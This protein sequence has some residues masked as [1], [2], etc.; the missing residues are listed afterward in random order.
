MYPASG[1]ALAAAAA[2]VLGALGAITIG[3]SEF[4]RRSTEIPAH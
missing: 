4:G 2:A 1:G 3:R